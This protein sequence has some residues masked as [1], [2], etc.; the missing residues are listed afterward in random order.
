MMRKNNIKIAALQETK[1]NKNSK[2]PNIPD[3]TL[4]RKDRETNSGGGL[5][6]MVH[7]TV[8]YEPIPNLPK[9]AHIES[10]GIKVCGNSIINIYIPPASSCA[11]G[12]IPNIT[13][14]LPSGDGYLLGD[15]NAHD[16]LW[17]SP[18]QD[19][20]GSLFNEIISDSDLGVLNTNAPTRLPSNN[21]PTSPDISLASLSL[22]PYTNWETNTRLGSDHLP[23]IITCATKIKLQ[24]S[25]K[26]TF[27]NFKKAN[28][29]KF[30]A[31]TEIEFSKLRAPSSVYKG[32]KAFRK[33]INSI[34]KTCI[35]KG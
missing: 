19:A 14:F 29:D 15:F 9:D 7:E 4:I 30:K 31:E 8:L 12:Y 32:E 5:A 17:Y 25:D 34:S 11:E 23:I 10:Q 22:L 16:Q 26:R 13:P 3:F 20:R 2:I 27:I 24:P 33:I 6:F 18:I 21:Q 28:W 35:P 1:F